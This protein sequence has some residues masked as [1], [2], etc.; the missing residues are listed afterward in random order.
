MDCVQIGPA[1]SQVSLCPGRSSASP[2]NVSVAAG[3]FQG[4]FSADLDIR[5]FRNALERIYHTL[6]GTAALRSSDGALD[7]ELVGNGTSRIRMKALARP[8]KQGELKFT[9]DLDQSALPLILSAIDRLFMSSP[10]E[11]D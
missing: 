10:N 4:S 11:P 2:V 6:D 7:V 1:N 9:A 5:I 3:P 8:M